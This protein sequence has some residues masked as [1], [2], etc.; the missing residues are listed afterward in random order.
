MAPKK[1]TKKQIE[2]EKALAEHE[3]KIAEELEKKRLEEEAERARIAEAKRL[4]E[5]KKRR[6]E[7]LVRLVEE[8]PFVDS[9]DAAMISKRTLAIKSRVKDLDDK[10]ILCDPLPDPNDEK[11]LTTFITLW[12]ESKDKTLQ[13]ATRNCQIAENVIKAINLIYGEALSQ[14]DHKKIKWCEDYIQ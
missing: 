7:E 5:E 1:K 9:R 4:A 10:F 3:R 2:E 12:R 6:E 14:Y 11:D 13:E 8:A